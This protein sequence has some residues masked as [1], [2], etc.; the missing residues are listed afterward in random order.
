[1][2]FEL[3][4]RHGCLW[5]V[6]CPTPVIVDHTPGLDL[7]NVTG[8]CW[9]GAYSPLGRLFQTT[10]NGVVTQFLYY[11]DALVIEYNG[12][13]GQLRR[14]VHGDQVDELWV[15]YSGVNI[16]TGYRTYLHA[17][18]QGSIIART[19]GSGNYLTKLTYD[20]FGIPG[21][22]NTGRFGYTGQIWLSQLGLF[23]YK[24]RMYSPKLGR[25]LQTDP[26]YYADQMNMY[27]YVGND[28]VNA[29]DPTGMWGQYLGS[30]LRGNTTAALKDY[31]LS[32]SDLSGGKVNLNISSLYRISFSAFLDSAGT[33]SNISGAVPHPAFTVTSGVFGLID[34]LNTG[35]AASISGVAAGAG[36]D[37]AI[38]KP[39]EGNTK[40]QVLKYIAGQAT[41]VL[42]SESVKADEN[43]RAS[44]SESSSKIEKQSTQPAHQGD[45]SSNKTK[46]RGGIYDGYFVCDGT[47]VICN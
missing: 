9:L 27:A 29:K 6:L 45:R 44:E 13:N 28:P 42:V 1:M 43:R 40:A 41:G 35:S 34:L 10:I 33:N 14:Y 31:Y 25:F 16:G 26:I 39:G 46:S 37:V 23:Y 32:R 21:T 18:H 4:P 11:G 5:R 38:P 19:D 22:S 36:S 2:P 24:A 7:A 3:Q 20:S 15:E 30:A 17:D 8:W 12:S 47:T